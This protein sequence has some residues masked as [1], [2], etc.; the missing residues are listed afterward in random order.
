[1]PS[2]APSSDRLP[3]PERTAPSRRLPFAFPLA[4]LIA[5]ILLSPFSPATGAAGAAFGLVLLFFALRF[6]KRSVSSKV[7]LSHAVIFLV[8]FFYP[9]CISQHV[10]YESGSFRKEVDSPLKSPAALFLDSHLSREPAAFA[11]A[12]L[13]NDRSGLTFTQKS[14]FRRTGLNHILA[15][16]GLH[17][18]L[19]GGLAWA[20]FR[21]LLRDPE[22]ADSVTIGF[23]FVYVL[24]IGA[25]PSA[26]RAALIAGL[27][28]TAR[29]LGT[30][31]QPLNLLFAAAFLSLL[32]NP[33][34]LSHL[35]FQF[36]YLAVLGILLWTPR[37]NNLFPKNPRWFWTLFTATLGAQILTAPLALYHF[38]IWAPV[39]LLITPLLLPLF[40]LFLVS[41]PTLFL[42]GSGNILPLL[43][44]NALYRLASLGSSV[45]VLRVEPFLPPRV[46]LFGA[47]LVGLTPLATR[48][49]RPFVAASGLL[50]AIA[51]LYFSPVSHRTFLLASADGTGLL[52]LQPKSITLWNENLS[53]KDWSHALR[54]FR[55]SGIEHA[56]TVSRNPKRN[57]GIRGLRYR[58]PFMKIHFVDFPSERDTIPTGDFFPLD[59]SLFAACRDDTFS[60]ILLP[61]TIKRIPDRDTDIVFIRR[62]GRYRLR[63]FQGNRRRTLSIK[64]AGTEP[65]V[66]AL[67]PRKTIGRFPR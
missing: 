46:F 39:S 30:R 54:P 10:F 31:S 16:S 22:M 59:N 67:G 45:P 40:T 66:F 19:I 1:M 51:S 49:L 47:I 4:S 65:F 21:F 12:V 52:C 43:P 53:Q 28:L 13:L 29:I 6:R 44:Y 64:T 24:S 3:P 37:L 7:F 42:P 18:G 38:G 56:Y 11:R 17:I 35:G 58:Y 41:L 55:I 36:S 60:Y 14:L 2:R 25:P 61:E 33:F 5:G 20:L 23:L 27:F 9:A 15:I 48:R 26:V 62:D 63:L 50:A 57:R 8:L 32:W 34:L